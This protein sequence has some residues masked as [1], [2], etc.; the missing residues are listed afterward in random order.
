[1]QPI[2]VSL[3]IFA[4]LNKESNGQP[5]RNEI[6]RETSWSVRNRLLQQTAATTE[7]F[8]FLHGRSHHHKHLQIR[9]NQIKKENI[10]QGLL[11]YTLATVTLAAIFFSY[12]FNG[13]SME[14]MDFVGWI[15]FIASCVTHAA[16]FCLV[17]F[18]ALELPLALTGCR[19]RIAGT[20]LPAVYALL[21]IVA[22]VNSYVYSIYHFHINGLVL[23]MLT[24]PGAS[25]IFV[26]ST[27]EYV[28][29]ISLAAVFL[30][31]SFSLRYA[32]GWL[33]Q[34]PV[35]R[36]LNR[37]ILLALLLFVLLSQGIHI[38]GGA[39]MKGSVIETTDVLPYYFPLRANKLLG[40]LGLV[41]VEK[42]NQIRFQNHGTAVKYPLHPLKINKPEKALN[43]VILCIDSWNPRTF[44]RKCTPN[45][46]AFADHA[47]LFSHHLSAS[48][49]TSG[50]IFGLFTGV[51]A[52]YWKS[53]DYG[54][55]QPLLITNLLK[56]GYQVQAY[57]SA[58]LEYPPFAK[59]LF[60]DVKGLNIS[61]P[62][63][64]T[65]DRDNRITHDFMADLDKYDGKKP[66]FSFVFYD[67]AH[68]MELPKSKLYRFQPSWEYVD[69]MKLDNN[70][71]PTP[72]F[73]LYRNSVAEADSLIGMALNK[74]KEKDLLRNT[75]VIITGDHG[76][77]FNENH[78]NYWGHASNYSQYQIGTPLIYYYS[79]CTP[80]KRNYRTT[81]YDISPTLLHDVL[82]VSNPPSDYSMG[83]YLEDPSPRD[84]HL[85]GHDLY[86]AFI[87][88]D[89]TIIEKQGSGNLKIMDRQMRPIP[90]YPIN[91]RQ[92]QAVILNMNRFFK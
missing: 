90:G 67:M 66:F 12:I 77:E 52:Y 21:F 74:L 33:G 41:D 62:G 14:M 75:V 53:F 61:T 76:Q 45:I 57:P 42:L 38:Y 16:V 91:P 8:L 78:N 17:P 80:G 10:R 40:R 60:R 48:N 39:T 4:L 36:H 28:K 7:S 79:G 22:V 32:S 30:L 3:C 13:R 31:I 18:L 9:M 34:H 6:R 44:T 43:I 15:Y 25:E 51:S 92:L 20:V 50:G 87:R 64:T 89:G 29:A 23:E 26:F 35:C 37:N 85:V 46:C 73:N 47:E 59:M 88:T 82:G 86:Y 27:W 2:T 49:A 84:W 5:V 72:F 56:A 83:K 55:I 19:R 11:Y 54:N 71:D 68:N 24:G 81:H 63:R 58:T 65:Y 1:M 69:Y 70:T